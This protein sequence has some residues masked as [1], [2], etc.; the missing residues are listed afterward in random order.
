M[1]ILMGGGGGLPAQISGS[2]DQMYGEDPPVG[3][4]GQTWQGWFRIASW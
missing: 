2:P 4:G 3:G 1:Y